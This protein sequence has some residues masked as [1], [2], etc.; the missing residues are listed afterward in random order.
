MNDGP[1]PAEK[2]T[3]SDPGVAAQ[4]VAR[5]VE[6]DATIAVAES[7]SGG[8][9]VSALTSVPGASRVV[10]GAVVAY[11]TPVKASV[12]GVDPVLLAEQG[13]VGAEVAE[14]LAQG[15]RTLLGA[16]VGVATTGEAGPESGSGQPVGTV[17]LAVCG[18]WG[19]R[20]ARVHLEGGRAEVQDGAA[21]AALE[22]LLDV[23][24]GPGSR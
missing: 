21:R 1:A 20:G 9:L 12:L 22:L 7:V 4:V 3:Q 13:P 19:Q 23:L 8:R 16:Q 2:R 5:L 10:R 24:G 17:H 14:Q 6:L 11:A 18:S 15:V